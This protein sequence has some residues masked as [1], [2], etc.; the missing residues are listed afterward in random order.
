[1]ADAGRTAPWHG[2]S[3]R[4]FKDHEPDLV[5]ELQRKVSRMQAISNR[6]L[7]TWK[8]EWAV[9]SHNFLVLFAS[10]SDWTVRKCVLLS[11]V[12]S[13]ELLPG[14]RSFKVSL[15]TRSLTSMGTSTAK[16]SEKLVFRVR[17][18]AAVIDNPRCWVEQIQRRAGLAAQSGRLV[19]CVSLKEACQLAQRYEDELE[20]ANAAA[21]DRAVKVRRRALASSIVSAVAARAR[22]Q[23]RS[24]FDELTVHAR[25]AALQQ[26]R[27][28]TA[29][30]RLA[31]ALVRP[32]ARLQL[33]ALF[34]WADA[35]AADM[36]AA[37][38]V[39]AAEQWKARQKAIRLGVMILASLVRERQQNDAHHA[40]LQLCMNME[41]A[42]RHASPTIRCLGDVDEG[43]T[44]RGRGPVAALSQRIHV[45]G[46][47]LQ[48][49]LRHMQASRLEATLRT[50][51]LMAARCQQA[52]AEELIRAT[53]ELNQQLMNRCK[54][55]P[56][57]SALHGM[58]LSIR[59]AL[60]R[61]LLFAFVAMAAVPAR[62]APVGKQLLDSPLKA[63]PW[64]SGSL[65]GSL[66]VSPPPPGV[67]QR[68]LEEPLNYSP[69]P[70]SSE[71]NTSSLGESS[72]ISSISPS[73]D[74]PT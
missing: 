25:L 47:L 3:A 68:H 43:W 22:L 46:R 18:S 17:Q 39:L 26:L 20:Q 21:R 50:W 16:A 35:V 56:V 63:R 48:V 37:R 73:T 66:G 13:A 9:L 71:L 7:T 67:D 54:E 4:F 52:E 32:V 58:V 53:A 51:S 33:E 74:A 1:M 38:A 64:K 11:S 23:L 69:F 44:G 36:E 72:A 2:S 34:Q 40:L 57:E 31:R 6:T 70:R 59:A 29:E 45:A 15:D 27:R 49:A 5:G 55:V 41:D 60:L 8:R 42:R 30:R 14:D 12:Q 24:A 61:R 65:L 10:R 19:P 28:H 62:S